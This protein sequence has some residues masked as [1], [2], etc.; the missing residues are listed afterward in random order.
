VTDVQV[1]L[2]TGNVAVTSTGPLDDRAVKEAVDEA[3]YEV[4]NS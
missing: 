4:V 2:T 1:D 3:G